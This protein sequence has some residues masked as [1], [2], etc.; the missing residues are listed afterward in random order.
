[1]T[2]RNRKGN[3]NATLPVLGVLAVLLVV[4]T[5][6]SCEVIEPGHR[7][8][9]VTLGKV[10]DQV[11]PEGTNVKMPFL[12]TIHEVNVQQQTIKG[13]ASCFSQDL[14]TV[15]VQYAVMYRIPDASVTKLFK[16][17]KGDA[18][19]TLVDPRLQEALKQVSAAHNAEQLVQKRDQIRM[20]A[21]AKVKALVGDLVT[22]EDL[23]IVNVDLSDQLEHA[24]EQKMVKQQESLAK[25]YELEKEKQEA[26]ITVVKAT[27]EADAI[28]VKAAAI[29]TAPN[30]IDLEIIKKWDGKAP[31]TV[32]LG[33]GKGGAQVVMPVGSG[34]K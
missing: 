33:D 2:R 3:A 28:K 7:G 6:S 18:F 1:M 15:K 14:Q 8:V 12:T 21:L 16:D 26:E 19:Q 32:I 4:V 30:V 34:T 9:K 29:A 25:K 11:L 10:D 24:I 20:D 27:A 17:Y 22:I 23:S 5:A 31:Q 13:E